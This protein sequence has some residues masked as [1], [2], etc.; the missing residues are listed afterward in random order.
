MALG[1][2]EIIETLGQR[3]ESLL[4]GPIDPS[5]E[6]QLESTLGHLNHLKETGKLRDKP[7]EGASIPLGRSVE[8][9]LAEAL[10]QKV[11][12]VNLNGIP[13]IRHPDYSLGRVN[14]DVP[15]VQVWVREDNLLDKVREWRVE[16]VIPPIRD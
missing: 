12:G 10:A 5:W 7:S 16:A 3:V 11:G 1:E 4:Q 14:S 6:L 8:R 13:L 9:P 2:R 15:G